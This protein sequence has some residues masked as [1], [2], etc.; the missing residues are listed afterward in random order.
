MAAA[1]NGMA[2]HGG[3]IPSGASFLCFTDY[4]RPALRLAALMK[5]AASCT[6]SPTIR[7]A[8]AR[9]ARP[10][11]RS[12]ISPS[13]R[14]MPNMYLWRPADSVETVECWQAALEQAH[15]PSI[16]ALT[17]AEPAGAAQDPCRREPLRPRR[18]RDRA[19]GGRGAGVDL[20]L[21]LG[22]LA[23]RRRPGAP[24]GQGD[25]GAGRVGALHGRVLRP[26]RGLPAVGDRRRP[27]SRSASRRRCGRA[28]TRS[29]A[30]ARSSA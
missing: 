11:S 27:R 5:I 16:L 6:S 18:L 14:A 12:S 23:R 20:R 13:L 8:S 24:Q 30:T 28:G 29:S 19:G 3:F 10:T 17:P 1:C 22:G 15:S 2:V 25:R 21:R 4:A 7:S 26:A 9:T